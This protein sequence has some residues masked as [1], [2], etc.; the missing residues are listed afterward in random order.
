M[1]CNREMQFLMY[2]KLHKIVRVSKTLMRDG[3][4]RK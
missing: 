4:R 2:K 1:K 3:L